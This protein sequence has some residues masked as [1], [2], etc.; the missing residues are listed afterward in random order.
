[1]RPPCFWESGPE[2]VISRE[3][4]TSRILIYL[5]NQNYWQMYQETRVRDA[6]NKCGRLLPAQSYTKFT[7]R[8]TLT[9]REYCVV[10]SQP[11]SIS[12]G[13]VCIQVP[14][15]ALNRLAH[16]SNG[17]TPQLTVYIFIV[18]RDFFAPD[19]RRKRP[20]TSVSDL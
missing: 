12:I 3:I 15:H 8:C 1:M 13:R 5:F 19:S 6:P 17:G 11:G 7:E 20:K 9:T 18:V 4:S 14:W 10:I 16:I 2:R